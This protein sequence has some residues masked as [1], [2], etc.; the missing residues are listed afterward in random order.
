MNA[1]NE[2][3]QDPRFTPDVRDEADWATVLRTDVIDAEVIEE[4]SPWE[5]HSTPEPQVVPPTPIPGQD[6]PAEVAVPAPAAAP[7]PPVQHT[8]TT[9]TSTTHTSQV[10]VMAQP[11]SPVAAAI[12]GFFFGPLGL[13][14]ASVPAAAIMFLVNVVVGIFTLGL[15]LFLTWPISAVVGAVAASR[16]NARIGQGI[17]TT[18]THSVSAVPGA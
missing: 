18:A 6:R 10:I 1:S 15:G 17:T 11:K 16:H 8:S 4:T 14:Y 12:L 7:M 13:L 2:N 3:T 9:H 5:M